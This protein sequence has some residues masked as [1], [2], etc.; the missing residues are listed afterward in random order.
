M[1]SLVYRNNKGQL[2][3]EYVLL[4]AIAAVVS[5]IIVSRLASRNPDEP[6][7]IITGWSKVIQ[8]IG[9]DPVDDC[10]KPSCPN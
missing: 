8:S 7:A 1:K 3:I 4:L 2:I 10:L 6:G 5:G 9:S